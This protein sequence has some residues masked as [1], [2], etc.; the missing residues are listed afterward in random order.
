M[1]NLKDPVLTPPKKNNLVIPNRVT[2][3]YTFIP[4]I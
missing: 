4:Q 3:T 2:Q 1:P